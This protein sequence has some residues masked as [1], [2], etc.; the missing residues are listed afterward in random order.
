[1]FLLFFLS[2]TEVVQTPACAQFVACVQATDASRGTTT[3]VLRFAADGDCWETPAGADLCDH[4]CIN[5]LIFQQQRFPDV[6][7]P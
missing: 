6:C 4:A 1:M 5:G 2:C 7:A 3:D